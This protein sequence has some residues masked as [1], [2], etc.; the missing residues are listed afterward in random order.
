V[1][2]SQ[3]NRFNA[4]NYA[5]RILA[6]NTKGNSYSISPSYFTLYDSDGVGRD[7]DPCAGCPD[8][9]ESVTLAKGGIIEGI[10]YFY[11]PPDVSPSAV[12]YASFWSF[13]E[14]TIS[15]K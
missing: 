11:L 13:N 7:Y 10:I 14:V 2:T 9:L 12:R 5:I 1:N 15:L 3:W 6:K 8:K 4:S